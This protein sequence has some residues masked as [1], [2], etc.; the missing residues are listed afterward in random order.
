MSLAYLLSILLLYS[1]FYALHIL[2]LSC[3]F[4]FMFISFHVSYTFLS[5]I[6]S[7]NLSYTILYF[8]LQ[9]YT[10]HI[11]YFCMFSYDTFHVLYFPMFSIYY[12]FHIPFFFYILSVPCLFI[13]F[14]CTIICTFYILYSCTVHFIYCF[15]IILFI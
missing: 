7:Y 8:Y 10:F 3:S 13:S 4:P 2:Y 1:C 11:W 15:P 5:R 9:S 12:T 6:L 14:S